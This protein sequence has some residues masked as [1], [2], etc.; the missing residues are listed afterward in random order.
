MF[1]ANHVAG[2]LC[3]NGTDLGKV[4]GKVCRTPRGRFLKQVGELV[5]V[6]HLALPF[7][8]PFAGVPIELP[9]FD[10]SEDYQMCDAL[11]VGHRH[12]HIVRDAMLDEGERLVEAS[13]PC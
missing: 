12:R 11:I 9:A 13:I 10:H 6:Q 2:V 7:L 1:F 8:D 3:S 4:F 5:E